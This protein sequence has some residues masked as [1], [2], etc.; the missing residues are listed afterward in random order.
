MVATDRKHSSTLAHWVHLSLLTGLTASG[1]LLGFGLLIVFATNEVRS[2]PPPHISE[3]PTEVWHGNGVAVIDLGLMLL[4]AT[5]TIR[6]AV[7]LTGW[8]REKNWFFAIVAQTVLALLILSI[9][10]GLH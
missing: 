9:V 7:L 3:L 4:M 10:F 8:V 2:G 5:P 1:A 6:V